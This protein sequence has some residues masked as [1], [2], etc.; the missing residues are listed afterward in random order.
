MKKSYIPKG[1]D[2]Q[3]RYVDGAHAASELDDYQPDPLWWVTEALICA[4]LASVVLFLFIVAG[5]IP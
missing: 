5:L 3:S 2:Q 1:C 4:A